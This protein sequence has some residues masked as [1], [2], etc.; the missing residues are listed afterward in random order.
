[1]SVEN[2]DLDPGR[3]LAVPILDFGVDYLSGTQ[4]DFRVEE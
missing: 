3:Y 1:V 2:A 4:I